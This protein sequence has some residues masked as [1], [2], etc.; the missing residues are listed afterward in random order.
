M[1][2]AQQIDISPAYLAYPDVSLRQE[3]RGTARSFSYWLAPS[4]YEW[5][6]D[7]TD[8]EEFLSTN[9]LRLILHICVQSPLLLDQEENLS[10]KDENHDSTFGRV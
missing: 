4:F 7:G 9:S 3:M 6:N 2:Q 5:H 8:P 10:A 1:L